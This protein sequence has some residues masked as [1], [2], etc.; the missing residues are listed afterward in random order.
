MFVRNAPGHPGHEHEEA[1]STSRTWTLANSRAHLHGTFVSAKDGK[2]QIRHGDG[3]L[4]SLSI[5]Q[6]TSEDRHWIARR[7]AEIR[8]LN[9]PTPANKLVVFA[10]DAASAGA[11]PEMAKAF[12]PF[13]RLKA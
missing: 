12:D 3:K 2:A 13:A 9:E 5:E 8:K 1:V 6:L 7:E 4:V 11:A 10:P